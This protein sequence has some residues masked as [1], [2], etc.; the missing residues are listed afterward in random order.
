MSTTEDDV[1][2]AFELH[3]VEGI[4]G[5]LDEGFDPRSMIRGR[6]GVDWLL[7]M[8]TRSDPFPNRYLKPKD[9]R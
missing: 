3:S 6:P 5:A 7:E 9:N 4:R 1:L 8:Y 2:V